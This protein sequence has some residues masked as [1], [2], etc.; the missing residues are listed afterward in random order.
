MLEILCLV[1]TDVN[2]LVS[3][4]WCFF[5]GPLSSVLP[6]PLATLLSRAPL[7]V[8]DRRH[9]TAKSIAETTISVQFVP[10]IRF[11]VFDFGVYHHPGPRLDS[12]SEPEPQ[13]GH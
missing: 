1:T 4:C 5:H 8:S 13:P 7:S 12:D 2:T 3:D 9:Y 6:R 10:G 11:L